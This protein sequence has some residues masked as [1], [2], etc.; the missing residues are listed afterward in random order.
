MLSRLCTSPNG[1]AR[2]AGTTALDR[3][4]SRSALAAM[5]IRT[6]VRGLLSYA[7]GFEEWASTRGGGGSTRSARYRYRLWLRHLILTSQGGVSISRQVV[8]ELGPGE[9]MR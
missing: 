4:R 2:W 7:P 5:A 1:R 3:R 6:W 8:A 9:C